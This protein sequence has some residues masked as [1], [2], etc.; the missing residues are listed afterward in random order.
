MCLCKLTWGGGGGGGGGGGWWDLTWSKFLG[1]RLVGCGDPWLEVSS[2]TKMTYLCGWLMLLAFRSDSYSRQACTAASWA[3]SPSLGSSPDSPFANAS[4]SAFLN[5]SH[6][7][8]VAWKC[9]ALS[10]TS[11]KAGSFRAFFIVDS[12]GACSRSVPFLAKYLACHGVKYSLWI[13]F[14]VLFV[15]N[16]RILSLGLWQSL[17]KSCQKVQAS[18]YA[19]LPFSLTF[20]F[21]VAL[22]FF[23]VAATRT[24]APAAS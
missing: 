8:Q 4:R 24:H 15:G 18:R 23:R 9:F 16:R 22:A 14:M 3:C 13:N 19:S 2:Y 5:L 11:R 21:L 17:K 10:L 6:V 7:R 12:E 1:A 20:L